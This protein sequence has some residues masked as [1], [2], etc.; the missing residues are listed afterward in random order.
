MHD[1]ALRRKKALKAAQE[2]QETE[3]TDEAGGLVSAMKA[4]VDAGD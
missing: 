2:A 1:D 3:A 4:G